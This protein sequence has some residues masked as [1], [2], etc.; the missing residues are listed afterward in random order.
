[1]F[2]FKNVVAKAADQSEAGLKLKKKNLLALKANVSNKLE[3]IH[4]ISKNLQFDLKAFH[5]GP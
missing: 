1:M 2:D 3:H 4:N 5:E